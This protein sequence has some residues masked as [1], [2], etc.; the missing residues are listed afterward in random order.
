MI[1]HIT[2]TIRHYSRGA[3]ISQMLLNRLHSMGYKSGV[4]VKLKL[5]WQPI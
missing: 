3:Q 2:I 4:G 1:I 5:H